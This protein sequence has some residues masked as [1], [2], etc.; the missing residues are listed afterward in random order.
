MIC[1]RKIAARANGKFYRTVMRVA[2]MHILETVALS[3]R[4]GGVLQVLELKMLRF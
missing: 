3:K 2:I 1:E 4:Q